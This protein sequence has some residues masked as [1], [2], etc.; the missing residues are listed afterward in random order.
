MSEASTGPIG[1]PP[2]GDRPGDARADDEEPGGGRVRRLLV[3]TWPRRI[4]TALVLLMG[5]VVVLYLIGVIGVPT[6]GIEDRGDWGEVGEERTE[7]VTTV[8]VNNPNPVGVSLGDSVTAD[9][10][11]RMNGVGVAE[12]SKSNITVPA[13]NSTT[14]IRTDLINDRLADW[15]VEFVRAEETVELGVDATVRVDTPLGQRDVPV[16]PD[17]RTMLDDS[18]PVIDA[19]SAAVDATNGTYTESVGASTVNDSLLDGSGLGDVGLGG[20]DRNVT[21]GYEIRR[22]WATWGPV[23]ENETTVRFHMTVHNPGDVPVPAAP[24]G[25]GVD[26]DMNEVELFQAQSGELSPEGVDSDA[27]IPS[28]ETEEVTFDVT[29]DN[30]KVDDWFTS[31]VEYGDDP[32]VRERTDVSAEFSVVFREPATGQTFRIPSESPDAYECWFRTAILVDDQ[33]ESNTCEAPSD[34]AP[35]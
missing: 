24:D 23:T 14:E 25:V 28:N 7:I 10:G 20:D 33:R 31:H 1:D 2:D 30:D 21:V 3:G 32:D 18:T 34:P 26:V 13:G 12:G 19:L 35:E 4:A 17:N 6:A 29:M 22:G 16:A 11:I 8:W 27:V 9:Y 15:W 5:V